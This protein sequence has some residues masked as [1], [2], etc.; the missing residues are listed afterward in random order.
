MRGDGQRLLV[1]PR[2]ALSQPRPRVDGETGPIP[3]QTRGYRPDFLSLK[4]GGVFLLQAGP[5]EPRAES[6]TKE[7]LALLLPG[8]H[9]WCQSGTLWRLHFSSLQK[10]VCSLD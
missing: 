2:L 8:G 4:G 5:L 1:S 6:R 7:L 3:G 9:R 10:Y